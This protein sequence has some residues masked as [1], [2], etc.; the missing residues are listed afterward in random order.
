MSFRWQTF[1]PVVMKSF[2]FTCIYVVEAL[3]D[4][5]EAQDLRSVKV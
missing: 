5:F 4:G 3:S 2:S 1:Y